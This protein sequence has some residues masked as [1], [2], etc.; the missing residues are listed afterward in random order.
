MKY[1]T[2][3]FAP[4][5]SRINNTCRSFYFKNFQPYS[6]PKE[7]DEIEFKLVP[8]AEEKKALENVINNMIVESKENEFLVFLNPPL[9]TDEI[10]TI[11]NVMNNSGNYTYKAVVF[12][13]S[14]ELTRDDYSNRSGGSL[15]DY[16]EDLCRYINIHWLGGNSNLD[17]IYKSKWEFSED[18][19]LFLAEY[20]RK[21]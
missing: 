5:D 4:I 18:V 19:N 11:K 10:K 17:K 7:V 2:L 6:S 16:Y 21:R 9:E 20:P 13:P 14:K 3:I 12:M 1:L 15:F 8:L